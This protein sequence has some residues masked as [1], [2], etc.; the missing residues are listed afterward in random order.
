MWHYKE[1]R[2]AV[3][4]ENYV[5]SSLFKVRFFGKKETLG[6]L[7]E[8]WCIKYKVAHSLNCTFCLSTISVPGYDYYSLNWKPGGFGVCGELV[9]V[10]ALQ[11]LIGVFE[12]TSYE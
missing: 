12:L 10:E 5:A 3:Q 1:I 4:E 8:G 9:Y 2:I 6:S 7:H 11:R